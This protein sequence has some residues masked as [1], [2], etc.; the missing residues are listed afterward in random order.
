[1]IYTLV[2]SVIVPGKM[3]DYY[4]ISNKELIP[5]F[6]KLGMALSGSF[7]AYTGNMNEIYTL[8]AYKDMADFQKTMDAQKNSK[9]WQRVSAKVGPLRVNQTMTI[10]EPNAWSPMK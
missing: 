3:A 2:T 4:E 6:P 9:E 1:M 8:N 7:H 10:L 5:L